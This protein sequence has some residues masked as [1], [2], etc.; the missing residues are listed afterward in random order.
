MTAQD[1]N[2]LARYNSEVARGIMHDAKWVG[3]MERLQ[4][5]WNDEQ[6][7]VRG[8]NVIDYH[9]KSPFFLVKDL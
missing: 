3:K 4:L 5:L 1:V 8:D 2:I 7:V 9:P 6:N